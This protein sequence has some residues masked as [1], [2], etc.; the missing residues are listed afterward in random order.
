MQAL[1]NYAF[2]ALPQ[3][4]FIEIKN[5]TKELRST[6]IIPTNS[7]YIITLSAAFHK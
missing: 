1:H 6:V 5:G 4:V 3:N 7:L 2:P